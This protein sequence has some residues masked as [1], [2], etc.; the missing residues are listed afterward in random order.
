MKHDKYLFSC[1]EGRCMYTLGVQRDDF[2]ETLRITAVDKDAGRSVWVATVS[3]AWKDGD[4][5]SWVVK[6]E[7]FQDKLVASN[8]MRKL[9]GFEKLLKCFLRKEVGITADRVGQKEVVWL[10]IVAVLLTGNLAVLS[11]GDR[12]R[13]KH[14]IA[15]MRS[16]WYIFK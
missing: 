12:V 7:T 6:S 3:T 5:L 14:L 16:N 9:I 10:L 4:Q 2:D 8:D 11:I 15:K 1:L 13:P